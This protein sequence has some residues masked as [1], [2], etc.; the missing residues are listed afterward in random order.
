LFAR[1]DAIKS[2]LKK[3]DLV[4]AILHDHGSRYV[5]KLY[6][7]QWMAER[8]FFDVK[9]FRDVVNGRG[10][11]RLITIEPTQSVADAVE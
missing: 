5:G 1:I 6:N 10:K 7:D 3:D 8:G 9:S 4:V 2:K 11:Q